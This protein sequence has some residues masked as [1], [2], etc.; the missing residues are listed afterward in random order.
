MMPEKTYTKK[1]MLIVLSGPSGTGKDTILKKIVSKD[2]AL[3]LSVSAT[4]R[5]PREGETNGKDYH[6]MDEKTFLNMAKDGNFLEYVKYCGNYYGTPLS[7]IDGL[8]DKEEDVILEIEIDGGCQVKKRCPESVS[9]FVVPPSIDVLKQRILNRGI[10]NVNN[11][12]DRLKTAEKE[13][14]FAHK[15]DYIVVNDDL[16]KCVSNILSI[17]NS[18][19]MKSSRVKCITNEVF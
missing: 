1:G 19:R 16:E 14:K 8:L 12:E 4:T 3:N 11:M 6:F 2:Q 10:S 9:I 5:H 18:E 13:L 15:Y 7:A 17:I